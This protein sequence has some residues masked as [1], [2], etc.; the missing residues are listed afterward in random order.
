M[1]DHPYQWE[2]TVK[3]A[4]IGAVMR[5]ILAYNTRKRERADVEAALTALVGRP[6]ELAALGPLVGVVM[7]GELPAVVRRGGRPAMA[8]F[9]L[10]AA[11]G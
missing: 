5:H 11:E 4:D 10:Q 2:Y 6:V 1:G 7:V 9:Q 8:C 3:M